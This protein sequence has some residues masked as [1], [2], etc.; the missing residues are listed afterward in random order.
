[1]SA[2]GALRRFLGSGFG[3]FR[4]PFSYYSLAAGT[5]NSRSVRSLTETF[6]ALLHGQIIHIAAQLRI[7]NSWDELQE[8]MPAVMDRPSAKKGN[9]EVR[10]GVK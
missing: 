2:A 7:Y 5:A 10:G 1:M 6:R 4:A 8:G 9:E 3:A